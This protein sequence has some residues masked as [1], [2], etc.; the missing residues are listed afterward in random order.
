MLFINGL[1]LF[2]ER[3]VVCIKGVLRNFNDLSILFKMDGTYEI[4]A[5]YRFDSLVSAPMSPVYNK[6]IG[7]IDFETYTCDSTGRPEVYA[8]G[9]VSNG[10]FHTFILGSDGINSSHQL[11]E[12]L[13]NSIFESKYSKYT[14][15]AHN[16]ANFD[17]IF[18]IDALSRYDYDVKCIVKDNNNI[19]SLTISSKVRK[20]QI[21][22]L[23][24]ALMI[25]GSLRVIAKSFKCD[26]Q[27]GYFPYNFVNKESLNYVG[28]VP[29]KSYYNDL[30]LSDYNNLC[31]EF[32]NKNWS[33]KQESLK[34]LEL[35]LLSLLEILLKFSKIVYDEY[36]L[37]ITD[38]KTISGLS[39]H[40][41][42][43]NFYENKY[44]IKLIK[45]SLEK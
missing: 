34:Y 33:V 4:N 19:V 3:L 7:C 9:W 8:G 26:K 13:F 44:N 39:L 25:K 16:L 32:K 27:K 17:S 35:D 30:S 24:S 21:N 20:L 12:R 29:A 36:G 28:S 1:I 15:Y 45:G 38:F 22:I 11:V 31:L 23:D 5:R 37:N 40:I 10:E 42:L 18:I 14:F 6:S 2:K 43:S 41:Y